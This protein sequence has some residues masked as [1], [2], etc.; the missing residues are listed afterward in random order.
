ML[1]SKVTHTNSTLLVKQHLWSHFSDARNNNVVTMM[2]A[3]LLPRDC[4][5]LD[6]ASN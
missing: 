3:H 1:K 5:T 2:N 6:Y 4:I